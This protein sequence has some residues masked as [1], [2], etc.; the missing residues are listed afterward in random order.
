MEV[1]VTFVFQR[2]KEH[3]EHLISSPS[4]ETSTSY[5]EIQGDSPFRSP[6]KTVSLMYSCASTWQIYQLL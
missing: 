4:V 6:N 3:L 2:E 1:V 5:F